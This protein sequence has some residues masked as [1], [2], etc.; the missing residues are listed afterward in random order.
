MEEGKPG[1]APPPP[2]LAGAPGDAR[3]A[4]RLRAGGRNL[5]RGVC[6]LVASS[7]RGEVTSPA[8]YLPSVVYGVG[9]VL[10]SLFYPFFSSPFSSLLVLF[11]YCAVILLSGI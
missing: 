2:G 1:S 11:P 10:R 7:L 5:S 9:G 8:F 6:P 3:P 4:Q